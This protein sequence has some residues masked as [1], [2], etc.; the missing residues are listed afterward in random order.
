MIS[1]LFP[2][3]WFVDVSQPIVENGKK[4]D[5]RCQAIHTTNQIAVNT[6]YN[7][8]KKD[9]VMRQC[10]VKSTKENEIYRLYTSAFRLAELKGI[11][12]LSESG[13]QDIF[14]IIMPD[15][16]LD[17][18]PDDPNFKKALLESLLRSVNEKKQI[19]DEHHCTTLTEVFGITT[20]EIVDALHGDNTYMQR[21]DK[22]LHYIRKEIVKLESLPPVELRKRKQEQNRLQKDLLTIQKKVNSIY[23][24]KSKMEAE[25][26]LLY[27][28]DQNNPK[29]EILQKKIQGLHENLGTHQKNL[30]ALDGEYQQSISFIRHLNELGE[31]LHTNKEQI[32]NLRI[33]F[34]QKCI[35]FIFLSDIPSALHALNFYE[36]ALLS[37]PTLIDEG[38]CRKFNVDP[39]RSKEDLLIDLQTALKYDSP[40][41]IASTL[42]A[43]KYLQSTYDP[44]NTFYTELIHKAQR[45][46][47]DL[48]E[49]MIE[50]QLWDTPTG[51][52]SLEIKKALLAA[53]GP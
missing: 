23:L 18:I 15:L 26:D 4:L 46:K 35:I 16:K 3:R 31:H 5:S 21:L 17:S 12:Y 33:Q 22:H 51:K 38:T 2:A 41:L 30:T 28:K 50:D 45:H 27:R 29:I 40:H 52:L 32:N 20:E 11:D 25:L 13:C 19:L 8:A 24:E 7:R 36:E 34:K 43:M 49:N 39:P 47:T 10:F 48:T 9:P 44:N 37:A 53:I 14:N 6:L 42:D 1:Y